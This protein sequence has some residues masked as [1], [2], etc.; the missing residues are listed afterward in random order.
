MPRRF[1]ATIAAGLLIILLSAAGVRADEGEPGPDNR[2]PVCGMFVAKYQSWVSRAELNGKVHYFDGAKDMMAF[3]FEPE[4]YQAAGKPGRISVKDYY[5][6][7]WIDGTTAFYVVGSDVYGPMGHE[8]VPFATKEA[9]ENF[10]KDHQ[11]RQVLGFAE[12]S[13]EL[14]EE[15]RHGQRMR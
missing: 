13:R 1:A 7:E 8:F 4:K 9:A 10:R 5:T 3:L 2:C 12:I 15:L 11:G 14:V 6:L